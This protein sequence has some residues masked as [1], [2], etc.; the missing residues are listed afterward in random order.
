MYRPF[1]K[2]WSGG[3][4]ESLTKFFSENGGE[5]KFVGWARDKVEF[6]I[7]HGLLPY[8]FDPTR[9]WARDFAAESE[10]R[11]GLLWTRPD[12]VFKE[13]LARAI[14]TAAGM[15]APGEQSG[16]SA[17]TSSSPGAPSV[18]AAVNKHGGGDLALAAA[19]SKSR[20]S[21]EEGRTIPLDLGRVL[22]LAAGR[23]NSDRC[24]AMAAMRLDNPP[25]PR[26][27]SRIIKTE[28]GAGRWRIIDTWMWIPGRFV[29]EWRGGRESRGGG[30]EED[31]SSLQQSAT[32]TQEGETAGTAG[33]VEATSTTPPPDP[34]A[35]PRTRLF[36]NHCAFGYFPGSRKWLRE[37]VGFVSLNSQHDS[38]SGKDWNPFYRMASR[39]VAEPD[40]SRPGQ[41]PSAQTELHLGDMGVGVEA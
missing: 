30:R 18:S 37:N 34:L 5:E 38:N 40:Q 3:L 24:G 28:V 25:S 19:P 29:A 1:G 15:S 7:Q 32:T 22:F 31:K 9:T 21:F 2:D 12:L 27:T 6:S 39:E 26:A 16:M 11:H 35:F 17:S 4:G 33:T 23:R 20:F 36:R 13:E 14:E 10:C 41:T 8:N